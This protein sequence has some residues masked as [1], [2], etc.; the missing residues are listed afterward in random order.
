MK[1]GTVCCIRS[2]VWERWLVG[3]DYLSGTCYSEEGGSNG[4]C[5]AEL[6]VATQSS[7]VRD[8][9]PTEFLVNEFMSVPVDRELW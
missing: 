8:C 3:E 4:N 2:Q 1:K 7:S 9:R 6:Q 5:C